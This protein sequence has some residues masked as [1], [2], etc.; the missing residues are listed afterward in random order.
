ME[1]KVFVVK[2]YTK[3]HK[4]K[5]DKTCIA[6]VHEAVGI[7]VLVGSGVNF[8]NLKEYVSA[9]A[10]IVGSSLKVNGIW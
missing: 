1:Q 5:D 4:L 2:N 9:N 8:E 10:I 3:A 7:P 6:E